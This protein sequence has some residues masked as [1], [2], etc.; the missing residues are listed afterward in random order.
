MAQRK[1]LDASE[2]KERE[3]EPDADLRAWMNENHE[4][5]NIQPTFV[6]VRGPM[7]EA[8]KCYDASDNKLLAALKAEAARQEQPAATDAVNQAASCVFKASF[9][10]SPSLYGVKRRVLADVKAC[11][12][13]KRAFIATT[14]QKKTAESS[15]FAALEKQDSADA[16]LA[17]LE[18]HPDDKR[19]PVAV[20]HVLDIAGRASG[21]AQSALD[22]R[23]VAVRPGAI[24]SLPAER[25]ILLV[26]PKGARVRDIRK[27]EQ[28]KIAPSIILARVKASNEPYKEFDGDEMVALKTMSISDDVV[29]AMIEV[30]TKINERRRADEDRQAIRA[31]LASLKKMI[32]EKK[33]AS[34]D[35][36]SSGQVVQTSDGPMDA[37]ASCAKRLAAVKLCDQLPF[38]GST[39]CSSTAE[40]SFPCPKN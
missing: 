29:A 6:D 9:V 22:E 19:V 32:E 28:A 14:V 15:E 33:A 40:S 37:L 4:C 8:R 24:I 25:R 17:F 35:G 7:L 13:R 36:K 34:G 21:D 30:T 16:W 20:K 5:D 31:E 18:A 2:A 10:D 12:D 11:V 38:P 3:N 39:I 27:M 23:L 26:G 1:A